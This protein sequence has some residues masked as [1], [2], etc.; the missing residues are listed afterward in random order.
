MKQH[1]IN[2]ILS[3]FYLSIIFVFKTKIKHYIFYITLKAKI[4]SLLKKLCKIKTIY[5]IIASSSIINKEVIQ[6]KLYY[7]L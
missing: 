2:Y 4:I 7:Y 1:D 6:W 5:G 3:E